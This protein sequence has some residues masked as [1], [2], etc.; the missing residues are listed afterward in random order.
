MKKQR[1]SCNHHHEKL[2]LA[3]RHRHFRQPIEKEIAVI[4]ISLL[5][6][7]YIF[8]LAM[9]VM[10]AHQLLG[11]PWSSECQESLITL[12]IHYLPTRRTYGCLLNVNMDRITDHL[13]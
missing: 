1:I 11:L 3:E 9:R 13:P 5:N 2:T 6:V 4:Y 7:I 12:P 10:S 8:N